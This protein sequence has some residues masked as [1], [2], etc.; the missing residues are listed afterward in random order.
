[1]VKDECGMAGGGESAGMRDW[2]IAGEAGVGC[3]EKRSG[4]QEGKA[5]GGSSEIF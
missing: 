4:K 2:K 1:M 5:G 3:R